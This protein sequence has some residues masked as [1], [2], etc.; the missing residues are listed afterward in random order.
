VRVQ[1]ATVRV[2]LLVAALFSGASATAAPPSAGSGKS[3]GAV[4]RPAAGAVSRPATGKGARRGKAR[5]ALF[6][7]RGV[8][9]GLRVGAP[10]RPS[11]KI[12]IYSVNYRDEVEVNILRDDGSYDE[13]ALT[14]LNHFVRARGA[15]TERIIEPRLYEILSHIYDHF[16]EKV[17]EFVS[18]FRDQP[19]AT[20]YHYLGTAMDM[21]VRGVSVRELRDFVQTLDTGG[22]G[23]GI[24]PRVG[25]IHVD[26]RPEPSYYW[27]DRSGH[28]SGKKA[29]LAKKVPRS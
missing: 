27:V 25:F 5:Q 6:R 18:G 10:S 11:G 16:G 12:H 9:N 24:Y 2:V 15:D 22:M 19:R 13:E 28:S 7:G 20:S 26:I 8:F 17:L 4:N 3:A 14:K 21:R 23:L 1:S 29:K